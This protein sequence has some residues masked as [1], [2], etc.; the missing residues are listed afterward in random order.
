MV[1]KN[2]TKLLE[3]LTADFFVLKYICIV[4]IVQKT[5]YW[6]VHKM[7]SKKEKERMIMKTWKTPEVKDLAISNTEYFA[8]NGTRQ[9]G[10]YA[11]YD[12][13]YVTPTYSGA[14]EGDI[15]FEKKNK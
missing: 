15:P 5:I 12:G 6:R 3:I 7:Y 8:L 1:Q 10:E 14:Y 13:E 2:V 4:V 11:S 9:D